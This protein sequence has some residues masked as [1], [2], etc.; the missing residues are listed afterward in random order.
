MPNLKPPFHGSR[1]RAQ[2][3]L[4]ALASLVLVS[5]LTE[6]GLFSSVSVNEFAI[7]PSTISHGGTA[8]VLGSIRSDT[9]LLQPEFA[10]YD[11]DGI[12]QVVNVASVALGAIAAKSVDLEQAGATLNVTDAACAGH[13]L[14]RIVAR[15]KAGERRTVMAPFAVTNPNCTYGNPDSSGNINTGS[16]LVSVSV[17][18]GNVANASPGSVDLDDFT[19]YTHS[20]AKANPSRIE[21]Y[22]GRDPKD[23]SDRLLSPAEAK[24]RGIGA[25]SSGPATWG[26]APATAFKQVALT[27]KQFEGLVNQ[28]DID[29]LWSQGGGVL[30]SALVVVGNTYVAKTNQGK[31]VVLRITAFTAGEAGILKFASYR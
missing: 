7:L 11:E 27:Q 3:I 25:N 18:L 24:T 28:G 12:T 13:Y 16:D 31:T 5:C 4:A 21:L 20:A 19:T 26:N 10:V 14:L 1:L 30:S 23:L 2:I 9:T 6:D 8:K 29:A 22:F 15:D 17:T